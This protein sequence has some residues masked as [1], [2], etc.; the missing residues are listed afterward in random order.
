MPQTTV[1]DVVGSLVFA[2][3]LLL[4]STIWGAL[5]LFTQLFSSPVLLGAALI[6]LLCSL[7]KG[8]QQHQQRT[9]VVQALF[10]VSLAS[11]FL[12]LILWVVSARKSDAFHRSGKAVPF[13]WPFLLCTP[14]CLLAVAVW[15]MGL[16]SPSLFAPVCLLVPLAMALAVTRLWS[17]AP[18]LKRG[19]EREASLLRRALAGTGVSFTQTTSCGMHVVEFQL[20]HQLPEARRGVPVLFLHGYAS[21]SALFF[22]NFALIAQRHSGPVFSLDWRGAGLSP[23]DENWPTGS[24]SVSAAEDFF[25]DS[26][27]SFMDSRG[28]PRAALVGHSMGGYFATAMLLKYPHRVAGLFLLSPAGWSGV[29]PGS[30]IPLPP[31]NQGS[32]AALAAS[33]NSPPPPPSPGGAGA[34]AV[35][36]AAA[37]DLV[38]PSSGAAAPAGSGQVLLRRS[39][40]NASL[41]GPRGSGGRRIP[42]LQGGSSGE[43]A[44]RTSPSAP[45]PLS[46]PAEASVALEEE[47]LATSPPPEQQG[48]APPRFVRPPPLVWALLRLGFEAGV[49]PG[50]IIRGLG[51]LSYPM[52]ACSFRVRAARWLLER[53]LSP[54]EHSDLL[55]YFFHSIAV[56]GVGEH[57]LC[58]ILAPGAYA[59]QPLLP[60]LKEALPK[61]KSTHAKA[62][63]HW[64]VGGTYDWVRQRGLPL[65][66]HLLVF[67]VASPFPPS[68]SP[69]PTY[70]IMYAAHVDE[71]GADARGL[72]PAQGSRLSQ[73]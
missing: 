50:L 70:P 8:L 63:F 31:P 7:F 54:E 51:P 57:C 3:M 10:A 73:H 5:A 62:P 64:F 22:Q 17:C 52:V 71:Q 55:N 68:L 34:P 53:P 32:S 4:F 56:H 45:A 59:R 1:K 39:P 36:A 49:T 65:G 60:R 26:I 25:L 27:I 43:G 29:A 12:Q 66:A 47:A 41:E 18:S 48:G 23:R 15:A 20:A 61:L 33:A 14:A 13:L 16:E 11:V 69:S 72:R 9:Q 28:F 30:S 35:A 6:A 24:M 19:R 37:E 42:P 46:H 2:L 67:N 38:V 58:K 40:S 21:G 44:A